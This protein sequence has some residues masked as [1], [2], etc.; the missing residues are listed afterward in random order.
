ML[1]VRITNG[2]ESTPKASRKPDV[3]HKHPQGTIEAMRKPKVLKNN[4]NTAG[5]VIRPS[6]NGD[7]KSTTKAMRKP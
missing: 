5:A 6:G 3:H 7:P 1:K 4:K 2:P